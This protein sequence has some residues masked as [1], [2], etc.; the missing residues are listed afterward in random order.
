MER[1][2]H[3]AALLARRGFRIVVVG[4]P[5][6]TELAATVASGLTPAPINLAGRTT[7]GQLTAALARCDAFLGSDSGVM[8][9]AAAA[10]TPIAAI[11]GPSNDRAWGPWPG[12]GNEASVRVLRVDLPCSPCVY[13]GRSLGTPEGCPARTCLVSI[14]P[15]QAVAAVEALIARRRTVAHA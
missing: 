5:E 14:S 2:Q 15:A 3:T 4:G 10:G 7:V 1:F 6:E 8:H 11:F 13:V 9:L 12:R